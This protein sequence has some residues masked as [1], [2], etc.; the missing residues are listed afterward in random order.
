LIGLAARVSQAVSGGHGLIIDTWQRIAVSNVDRVHNRHFCT[1]FGRK[2]LSFE[3]VRAV[4]A[5]SNGLGRVVVPWQALHHTE[6]ATITAAVPDG[7]DVS[8]V[9]PS[10][11]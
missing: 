3:I 1:V 11:D 2:G 6:E 8:P 10:L 5:E 7:H 4:S 9:S